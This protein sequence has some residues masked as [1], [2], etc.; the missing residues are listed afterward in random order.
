[1]SRPAARY[2]R[3]ARM[4]ALLVLALAGCGGASADSQPP[5][6]APDQEKGAAQDTTGPAVLARAYPDQVASIDATS[7]TFRDGARLPLSDG[8]AGKSE[9]ERIAHADI[10]DMFVE[11]YRP[12]PPAGPP[13]SD[14]GRARAE[15]FFNHMYGDCMRGE[16]SR[17]LRP[18]RWM[19][20]RGGA[21]IQFTT[22]NHAADHLEAVI[23][24]LERLPPAM[25][26]YLVPSAGTFNCRS[27]AGTDQRSMHAWG[28]AV[29]ISTAQADYWRWAGGESAH[30]RNRIPYEIVEIFERH[31]FIWGGKWRHF[32]TM[33]FE[34]RPELL[35]PAD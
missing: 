22:V 34:Y 13:T 32:D 27:I 31:G 30:Y 8:I 6:P 1:M 23:A 21:P 10:D 7:L 26:R 24:E 3:V 2:A 15:A 16:T 35:P 5:R 4:R 33:H 28:A 11:R 17:R 19:A 12:G 18:V 29:D 25:T 14:P 9:A 20:G